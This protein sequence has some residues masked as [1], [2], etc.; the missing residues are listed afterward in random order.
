M[1][2]NITVFVYKK[3]PQGTFNLLYAAGSLIRESA[4]DSPLHYKA[5]GR[6]QQGGVR[7]I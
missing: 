3:T 1:D 4:L 6:P 2:V 7:R 5:V